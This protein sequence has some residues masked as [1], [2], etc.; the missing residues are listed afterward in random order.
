MT[1][2][3]YPQKRFLPTAALGELYIIDGS[4]VLTDAGTAQT[5]TTMTDGTVRF[6]TLNGAD[7]EI[8]AD[9]IGDYAIALTMSFNADKNCTIHGKFEINGVEVDSSHFERGMSAAGLIGSAAI[10][11]IGQATA[12]GDVLTFM[13]ESTAANTTVTIK[14]L[15]ISAVQV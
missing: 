5:V 3:T 1:L 13:L 10:S 7:G 2:T 9:D 11:S 15:N 8:I 6:M 14:H 4:I 12:V